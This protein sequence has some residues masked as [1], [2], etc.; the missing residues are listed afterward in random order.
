[1]MWAQIQMHQILEHPEKVQ[2]IM[3]NN[4]MVNIEEG[5]VQK[6]DMKFQMKHIV[7]SQKK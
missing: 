4:K 2:E 1:M 6:G 3:M 5:H 7:S